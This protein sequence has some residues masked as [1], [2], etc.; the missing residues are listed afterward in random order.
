MDV[1]ARQSTLK[2]GADQRPRLAPLCHAAAR[3]A[4]LPRIPVA[5][6]C[7]RCAS[8]ISCLAETR[9]ATVM[10]LEA[11]PPRRAVFRLHMCA[12]AGNPLPVGADD[13]T[14]QLA[15]DL[16]SAAPKDNAAFCCTRRDICARRGAAAGDSLAVRRVPLAER[17]PRVEL[18]LF[19]AA[20]ARAADD[21]A[22]ELDALAPIIQ[23]SAARTFADTGQRFAR[24]TLCEQRI[25]AMLIAGASCSQIAKAL[26][27]SE[28]TIH[29]HLKSLHKKLG[30]KRRG[31]LIARALG[32]TPD[33]LALHSPAA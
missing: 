7:D 3:L 24:V 11:D 31:D 4:R 21:I 2:L 8:I 14:V 17:T 10:L 20:P 6:W 5:D 13:D 1:F 28:H 16:F 26:E 25:I 29:D 18:V 23:N 9:R 12:H 19:A 32:G 22:D 15:E 30:V 27:R 33:A